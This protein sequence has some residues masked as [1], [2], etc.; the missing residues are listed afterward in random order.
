MGYKVLV[1][2]AS[3]HGAT[4]GIAERLAGALRAASIDVDVREVDSVRDPDGYDGYVIG[5]ALYAGRWLGSASNFVRL[6]RALLSKHPVWLFSSGPL[7]TSVAERDAA[8]PRA[9]DDLMRHLSARAH[10]VFAGAWSR[11]APA[12]GVLERAMK[13]IPAGRT[14]L[15]DGDFRPW[16]DIDRFG[17]AIAGEL[18][19]ALASA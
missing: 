15:P 4:E 1:A 5:S 10:A 19:L 17:E 13:L 12:I 7:S 3:R 6:H 9:I 16:Q 11:D 14:A 18:K 8:K 2:Y